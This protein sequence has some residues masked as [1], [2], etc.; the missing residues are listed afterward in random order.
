V[1]RSTD[2][3]P[4]AVGEARFKSD[5]E[6]AADLRAMLAASLPITGTGVCLQPI[7]PFAV[8]VVRVDAGGRPDVAD[9]VRVHRLEG[10]GEV[11]SQWIYTLDDGKLLWAFADCRVLRPARCRF[12][13]AFEY[14]KRPTLLRAI[15]EA[16]AL[17]LALRGDDP[18]GIFAFEVPTADLRAVL[19]RVTG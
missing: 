13:L 11:L 17:G 6:A 14:A 7:P 16:G 18:E 10:E 19:A 1:S 9:L 12:L 3:Y 8:P 15:A 2:A 5:A 4:W